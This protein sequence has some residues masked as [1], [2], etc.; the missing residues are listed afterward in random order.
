MLL[1][2][3][4][5]GRLSVRVIGNNIHK[6]DVTDERT[7]QRVSRSYGTRVRQYAGHTKFVKESF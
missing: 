4:Q 5:R 1:K 7:I 6:G 2:C 3:P